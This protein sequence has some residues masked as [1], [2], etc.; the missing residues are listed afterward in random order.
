MIIGLANG[1]EFN[2]FIRIL[3][4][5]YY[6]HY[7]NCRVTDEEIV[8]H[9]TNNISIYNRTLITPGIIGILTPYLDTRQSYGAIYSFL[10]FILIILMFISSSMFVSIHTR[11]SIKLHNRMF[12]SIINA[13]MYFFNTNPSGNYRIFNYN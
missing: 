6:I 3:E 10:I 13:T 4:V 9:N 2:L 12:N 5:Q 1:K 7:K 8:Y 11:S